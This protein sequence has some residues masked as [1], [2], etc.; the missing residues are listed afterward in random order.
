M[1]LEH[2]DSVS[3]GGKTVKENC[4]LAHAWCNRSARNL[5]ISEKELLRTMFRKQV[6][7]TG[8]P[9]WFKKSYI[10]KTKFKSYVKFD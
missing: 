2:L 7:E 8:M 9:P 10:G 4:V 1:T 5:P 6:D 3:N